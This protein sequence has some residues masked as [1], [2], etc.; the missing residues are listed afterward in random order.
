MQIKNLPRKLNEAGK[1]KIGKKGAETTSSTGTVFRMPTRLDHFLITTTERDAAGD[2]VPD[3]A[4]MNR[5][6]DEKVGIINKNG[7]L[8]GI[9]IR[10]LYEDTELNFPTRYASY[11]KGKLSCYGDGVQSWSRL[12]DFKNSRPCPCPRLA[13]DYTGDDKCKPNGAL[14]CVIDAANLFGQVHIFRTTSIN[15]VMGIL[16]GIDLIKAATKGHIAGI[17]LML[18]VSNKSTITPSGSPTTVQVVSICYRGTMDQLRQSTLRLLQDEKQFLLGMDEIEA[19]ARA[20]GG[21]VVVP[22]SEEDEFVAEFAPGAYVMQ[23]QTAPPAASQEEPEPVQEQ[24]PVQEQKEAGFTP[25]VKDSELFEKLESATDLQKAI[26]YAG[27]LCKADLL[28]FLEKHYPGAVQDS[29]A[30]KPVYVAMAV[31]RLAAKLTPPATADTPLSKV[32]N[33]EDPRIMVIDEVAKVGKQIDVVNAMRKQFPGQIINGTLPIDDLL[34]VA[35]RL[36]AGEIDIVV[37]QT[38]PIIDLDAP[39]QIASTAGGL[40][41]GEDRDDPALKTSSPEKQETGFAWASG[42]MLTSTQKIEIVKIKKLL[43]SKG[44]TAEVWKNSVARFTGEDGKPL[45]SAVQMT[46]RQA[47]YFIDLLGK[48]LEDIP[49]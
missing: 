39:T 48:A 38:P 25:A 42:S 31:E 3:E 7:D 32:E 9:P 20:A 36:A 40:E 13:A 15:S 26:G 21:G 35:K 10:L 2:Y 43:D 47:E 34:A 12:D 17:P 49:F 37:D 1:I 22:E 28:L 46:E 45:A 19:E 16:G 27:R 18:V 14:T 33:S 5:I 30:N 6:K 41:P 4:L 23:Q 44:W 8:I 24:V 11:V 29:S